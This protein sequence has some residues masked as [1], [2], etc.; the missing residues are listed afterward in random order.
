M[1]D[2]ANIVQQSIK[3]L[4][5]RVD[6]SPCGLLTSQGLAPD[7]LMTGS[8]QHEPYR[9]ELYLSYSKAQNVM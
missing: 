7:G 4:I 6:Q 2:T 9:G 5:H 1:I 8:S 3:G